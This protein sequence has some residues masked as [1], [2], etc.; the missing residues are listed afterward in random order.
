MVTKIKTGKPSKESIE[1]ERAIQVKLSQ[2]EKLLNAPRVS[3]GR[4]HLNWLLQL[5]STD[6]DNVKEP[7][8]EDYW[9]KEILTRARS[10]FLPRPRPG[11]PMELGRERPNWRSKAKAVQRELKQDLM[12]IVTAAEKTSL[13]DEQQYKSFASELFEKL[14]R[15]NQQS[16]QISG[17]PSKPL[18]GAVKTIKNQRRRYWEISSGFCSKDGGAILLGG[19]KY[20]FCWIPS[21]TLWDVTYFHL[22]GAIEVGCLGDL[23]LCRQCRQLYLRN[24]DNQKFCSHPC[25]HAWNNQWRRESKDEKGSNVFQQYR[26]QRRK[27]DLKKAL[28]LLGEGKSISRIV[29]ETKLTL[30]MLKKDHP[31]FRSVV[32]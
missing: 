2:F 26:K 19:Q 10:E 14:R 18:I 13:F 21:D 24:K 16:S 4:A 31:K 32:P 20:S 6:F 27:N 1:D 12:T 3:H 30:R 23:K 7:V 28:R 9:R 5:L 22:A 11:R 17:F 29:E 25:K 8:E 15:V